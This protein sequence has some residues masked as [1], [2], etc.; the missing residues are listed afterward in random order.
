MKDTD[1]DVYDKNQ[2]TVTDVTLHTFIVI[3]I[4]SKLH[5]TQKRKKKILEIILLV[6]S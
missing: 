6:R 1:D 2:S 4:A 3:F 5:S